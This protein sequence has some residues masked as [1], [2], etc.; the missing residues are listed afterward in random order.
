MLDLLRTRRSIRAFDARPV[1]PE[2]VAA[3]KEA[4]LRAPSSRS[5][6]PWHFLFVTNTSLLATLATCKPHGAGFLK[7]APLGVVVC[8][9]PSLCDV[10]VE[11][12]SIASLILHLTAHSLGLGS[13][14]IQV[15]KRMHEQGA[16]ASDYIK[17]VLDLPDHLEVES[18]IA[19]GYPK[20]SPK[21]HPKESLLWDRI[22]ER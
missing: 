18:I 2:L 9:D 8:A 11:D 12:A 20:E 13:C 16:P 5:L 3:L 6:N 10:W 1:A 19:M 15:R 7:N 14:W 21:G 17:Q 22:E 4:V